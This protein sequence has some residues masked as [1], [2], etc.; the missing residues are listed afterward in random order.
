MDSLLGAF[1]G[2]APVM[3]LVASVPTITVDDD[4]KD[5]EGVE[6]KAF[7]AATSSIWAGAGERVVELLTGMGG[8]TS[9]MTDPAGSGLVLLIESRGACPI[10]W[11]ESS[12]S[13]E[14][15]SSP[16]RAK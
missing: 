11:S 5:E 2:S 9:A 10:N 12:I 13:E 4:D 7:G 8:V 14:E 6:R 15:L 16:W 3:M 1:R